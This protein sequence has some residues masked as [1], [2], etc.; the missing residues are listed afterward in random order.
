M[1]KFVLISAAWL[2]Q[3]SRT[4]IWLVTELPP[5]TAKFV[6]EVLCTSAGWLLQPLE[7]ETWLVIELPNE[8]IC[9]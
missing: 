4:R 9:G 8:L 1:N 3:P 6:E 7:I 2:S 5:Q